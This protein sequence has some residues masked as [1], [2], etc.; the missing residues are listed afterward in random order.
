[1]SERSFDRR[2]V[3]VQHVHF[4]WM[5]GK[6]RQHGT[7]WQKVDRY[8]V[9]HWLEDDDEREAELSQIQSPRNGS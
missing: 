7:A 3:V 6:D 8:G 9:L 2:F 1:M 5:I 4:E